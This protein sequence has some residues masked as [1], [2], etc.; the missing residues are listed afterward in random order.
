MSCFCGDV[1]PSTCFDVDSA[2]DGPCVQQYFAAAPPG[3]DPSFFAYELV[4][5]VS[6]VG[7]PGALEQ[8]LAGTPCTT[9]FE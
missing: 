7:N 1:D 6:P 3:V 5:P 4:D 9:C 2:P 8:C